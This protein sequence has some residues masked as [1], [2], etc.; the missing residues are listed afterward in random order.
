[1]IAAALVSLLVVW[2]RGGLAGRGG[3]GGGF[4]RRLWVPLAL[5]PVVVLFLQMP[6]SLGLWNLLPKLRFLQFPWRWLLAVEAPMAIF[7]TAAVWPGSARP[8]WQRVAAGGVCALLFMSGTVFAAENFFRD[9]K[10]DDDLATILENYRTGAGFVGTDE[11]A[12]AGAE[13]TLVATGLPD[14]CLTDDFDD[15]QGVQASPD[16]T[17]VWRPEQKSCISIA[18]ADPASGPERLRVTT[19]ARRAGFLVLK[20]RRYPAWRVTMNGR[21]MRDLQDR[22]DGLISVPV[23]QGAVSVAVDWTTTPDVVAGRWVS[24]LALLGLVGLGV[25]ERRFWHSLG[26]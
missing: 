25:V 2:R 10:E 4:P 11:Y 23:P 13:N 7:F 24:G 20:L 16:E 15:E 14:A 19:N 26:G 5:I 9:P 3:A 6:L 12:P 21:V 8:R 22:D 18:A 17:P 1:M